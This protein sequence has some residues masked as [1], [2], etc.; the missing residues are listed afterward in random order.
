WPGERY[1]LRLWTGHVHGLYGLLDHLRTAHPGVTLET[2]AGGGG[3]TDLGILARAGQV[4]ASAG[5]D[6]LD[7]LS[8]QHGFSQLHPA[9]VMTDWVTA[10]RAPG[11]NHRTGSLRFRFTGAMAGVLGLDGDLLDWGTQKRAEAASWI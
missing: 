3:R 11:L 8:V 4:T 6:P 5:T 7:R 9:V 1:P 10:G 2:G